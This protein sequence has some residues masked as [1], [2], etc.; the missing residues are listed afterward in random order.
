MKMKHY[1][2]KNVQLNVKSQ[3]Y[4]EHSVTDDGYNVLKEC[5]TEINKAQESLQQT[6]DIIKYK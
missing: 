2:R 3:S 4:G 6:D 5:N 1:R